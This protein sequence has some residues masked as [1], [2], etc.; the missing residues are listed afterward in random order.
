MSTRQLSLGDFAAHCLEEI[1]AIQSGDTVLEILS[2]GKI[3]ALVNPAPQ[4]GMQALPTS[5][6]FRRPMTAQD[7]ARQQ[8]IRPVTRVEDF[9]GPGDEADWEGFDEALENWR[10]EPLPEPPPGEDSSHAA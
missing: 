2:A 3:V 9:W 7:H 10:T 6:D 1:Q 8:G 4:S 5:A